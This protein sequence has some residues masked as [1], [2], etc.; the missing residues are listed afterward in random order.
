M[1]NSPIYVPSH[2]QQSLLHCFEDM[3][4]GPSVWGPEQG[5]GK[6]KKKKK[7]KN[8]M[9]SHQCWKE[10]TLGLHWGLGLRVQVSWEV[11]VWIEQ[12]CI[13][14][15][16]LD[17]RGSALG[18][19]LDLI[20][21]F[22]REEET[23]VECDECDGG[24]GRECAAG[25]LHSRREEEQGGRRGWRR[26]GFVDHSAASGPAPCP[27][28]VNAQDEFSGIVQKLQVF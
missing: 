7:K 8:K 25:E 10:E 15:S 24:S 17:G 2:K 12:I 5:P 1:S 21:E 3:E 27:V 18:A 19:P 13:R 16:G 23:V 9:H 22:Q 26:W 6:S 20:D 4:W 11:F 14:C 28:Y